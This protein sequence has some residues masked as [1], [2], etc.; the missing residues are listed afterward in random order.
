MFIKG[1]SFF[2]FKLFV[3]SPAPSLHQTQAGGFKDAL[4]GTFIVTAIGTAIAAPLGVGIATW[5]AEY[6][7]PAW[8]A[9]VGGP[10]IRTM[11]GAPRLRLPACGVVAS[12]RRFF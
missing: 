6:A 1:I 11:A 2:T 7:P 4:I 10:A 5:L 3:E 9:R 8:L 12:L